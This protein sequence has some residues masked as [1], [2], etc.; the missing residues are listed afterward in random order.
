[1]A[2]TNYYYLFAGL[3]ILLVVEPFLAGVPKSG[4][5]IQLAFTAMMVVGAFDLAADG[6]AFHVGLGFAAIGLVTGVGFYGSDRVLLGVIDLAAIAAFCILAIAL[7]LRRVILLPGAITMNRIVGA[8]CIYLL[9]GVLWAALY[10]L[11][12]VFEPSAFQ[13]AGSQAKEPLEHSLYYSF[14]TLT[15]LGYGDMTPLHPVARTLAYLEAVVGQLY[16]AVLIAGLVGRRSAGLGGGL[17]PAE[18]GRAS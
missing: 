2:R 13:L 16:I 14:V 15:T 7:K 12:E 17:E 9:L 4:A 8:L 3:L 11:V 18:I 5:L 6:R 10:G 1:M